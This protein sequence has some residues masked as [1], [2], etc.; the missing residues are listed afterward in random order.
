MIG[1]LRADDR[2]EISAAGFGGGLVAGV[3]LSGAQFV[4]NTTGLATRNGIGQFIW[5]RDAKA[6]WWDH[7]GKGGDAAVLIA[8]L[9]PA[10]SKVPVTADTLVIA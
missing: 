3:A 8:T 10:F 9:D 6:L 2:I 5:E 4:V 7:D 1:D